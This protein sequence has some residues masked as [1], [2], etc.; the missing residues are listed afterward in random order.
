MATVLN[1]D[2][3]IG[4]TIE[5]NNGDLPIAAALAASGDRKRGEAGRSGSPPWIR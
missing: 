2:A 5:F 3:T 4:R 1:D